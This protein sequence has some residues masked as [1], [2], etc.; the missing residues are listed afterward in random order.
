MTVTTRELTK[1]Y[2]LKTALNRVSVTFAGGEIHALVGEN[3]AGKSTL[4]GLLCGD[5][6][7]TSGD[8]L[9]DGKPTRFLGAKDA[10][11]AG[12]VLVHQ[13]PLLASSI[14][15]K[16]N[17][18]LQLQATRAKPPFFLHAP[19]AEMLRLRD[20]WAAHLNL[21]ALVKDLGGNMRF[22]VSLLGAL[23]QNP[24]VLLL[25]EPSAFLDTDE[26]KHLYQNLRALATTGTNIIVITH[27]RAEATT[28]ADTVTL[29]QNG[30]LAARFES[31]D[32][33]ATFL[34]DNA[35]LRRLH[36]FEGKS[37]PPGFS[38]AVFTTPPS[39]K[40]ATRPLKIPEVCSNILLPQTSTEAIASVSTFQGASMRL[41]SLLQRLYSERRAARAAVK[42][43]P[44]S[45]DAT[46]QQRG[47]PRPQAPTPSRHGL[48]PCPKNPLTSDEKNAITFNHV[49]SR[50]KNRP[51]LLDATLSVE[52]GAITAVTGLQEA[53]LD[54]LEDV[55]TGMETAYAKGTVTLTAA[56]GSNLTVQVHRLSPQILRAH[57]TAIVP[58]D[59][60]FRAANPN[61][62]VE[63]LLSVYA[64]TDTRATAL[65]LIA[66]AEV[67]ITPEQMVSNLSGGM[68]Q[69]LILT[70][71]LATN[72]RLVI[73]CNPMQ[74]LDIQAQGEL[75]QTLVSLAQAGK[76]ILVLGTQEFPLSLC[77]KVYTLESGT[78]HLQF[79]A[80]EERL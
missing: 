72:P 35:D 1:T 54:T 2:L 36:S 61:I 47:F 79:A 74:G 33:Y 5:L 60:N 46:R 41:H 66:R 59:R 56:D 73:L 63:Q 49:S 71:E 19:T 58:S 26:R 80:T 50:P 13:R 64:K 12:I 76:A 29:L 78:T 48:G 43:F 16:E 32:A 30:S 3:G 69:R 67:H 11:R 77:K 62:T 23:L 9:L 18:I 4:A 57:Q 52:Y 38:P 55:A 8:I 37:L 15:A 31:R 40:G 51:A 45:V 42:S 22:Y 24:R 10:L 27:S 28:Y 44:C 20:Q 75:C 39:P 21:N 70:R 7:P 65:D 68:L 6:E 53:A 14:T 25:D 34:A 17:I